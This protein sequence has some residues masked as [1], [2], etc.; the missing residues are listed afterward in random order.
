MEEVAAHF[1]ETI[2]N[3]SSLCL[4]KSNAKEVNKERE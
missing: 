3:R 4:G 1:Y 2:G